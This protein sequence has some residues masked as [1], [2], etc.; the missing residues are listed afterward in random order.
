[1]TKH[2]K[3]FSVSSIEKCG[4]AL[5]EA[6]NFLRLGGLVAIPTE[7]VYGLAADATNPAAVAAIFE[8]KGRPQDNPLIV[9][10]ASADMLPQVAREIPPA[11]LALAERFWPGPLTIIL[12]KTERIPS[13][14]SAGL[15]TVAIRLPAHPIARE[16]IRRAGVPLAAPSANR[17]GSPSTTT[18]QHCLADLDGRIDAIVDGGPCTVGVESTV[19]SL[20]GRPRL[21]RPGAVTPEALRPYLPNL[22]LDQAVTR[23]PDPGETVSSPG[24]KY[25][26]YAPH[27]QVYL[28]DGP[29]DRFA[30]WVN[31]KATQ[32][33]G[34]FAL[35]ND[36][37]VPS[38]RCG[39][40]SLGPRDDEAAQAARLFDC[41]RDLDARGAGTVYARCP[42]KAGLGLALYNRLVRAASFRILQI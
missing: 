35:C 12:P 32:A 30:P 13:V 34:V 24:M 2:T 11:A 8:A 16:L 33:E 37:D 40:V 19:V 3:L 27:C 29:W 23:Q 25:R 17:S 9:H 22:E 20:A 15:D 7:T 4:E 5:D 38:L 36:E 21:L 6:A 28:L 18:A 1:M 26:H 39:C 14:T 10:I 42:R 41:L 31:G